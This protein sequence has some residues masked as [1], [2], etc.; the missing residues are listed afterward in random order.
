MLPATR[1]S[2]E[3][4]DKTTIYSPQ[5]VAKTNRT[6]KGKIP[7]EKT[8]NWRS[9]E[10]HVWPAWIR[11][12]SRPHV[13]YQIWCYTYFSFVFLLFLNLSEWNLY[14]FIPNS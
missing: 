7:D 13:Y 10:K 9:S 3:S 11:A 1:L 5:Q 2:S 12:S 14:L 8:Q 4:K 6:G